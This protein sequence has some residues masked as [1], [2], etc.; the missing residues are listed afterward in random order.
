MRKQY[1]IQP[2][3]NGFYAWDV[4]KL[5]EKSKDLPQIS[6]K[7]EDI[8][9]LDKAYWYHGKHLKPT[10]RSIIDHV[11][12]IN[13]T[14]LKYPIILSHD[15]CV[16]DGMHRV[17]KALLSGQKEIQAVKFS[18]DLPPDYADV[19]ERELLYLESVN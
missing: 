1:Y 19:D 14:D 9:E 5:M 12:L 10:V 18:E 13:N 15:G 7:L 4:H 16:M 2:S 17:A 11:V 6:V 3:N 8:Q